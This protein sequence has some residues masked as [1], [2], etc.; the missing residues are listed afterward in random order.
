MTDK[1]IKN[2]L[3]CPLN[4]GL[5]HATR[6]IPV[7]E[8]LQKL[9]INVIIAAYGS[10][11][12]LLKKR[13][14]DTEIIYLSGFE[15]RYPKNGGMAMMLLSSFPGMI[16]SAINARKSFKRI[17]IEKNIDIV[18][19]DNRYEL[20]SKKVYSVFITHQLNIKTHGLQILAKP[21]INHIIKAFTNRFNEIWIPD[22]PLVNLSGSLSQNKNSKARYVGLLSRF[23]IHDTNINKEYDVV[24]IISGPE[25]QRT[26]FENIIMQQ[27]QDSNLHCAII[28][29]KPELDKSLQKEN[30]TV[31]P[32]LDDKRFASLISSAKLIISR[33]GYS[34][35][36][37]LANF[38]SKA[39]FVPTPGQTE[40]IYLANM[41]KK[42][43]IAYTMNQKDFDLKKSIDKSVYFSG[44]KITNTT[45]LLKDAIDS[46][47]NNG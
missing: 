13:F 43:Q 37:D 32:H 45:S 24:A 5:G 33:P 30:I 8:M 42:K 26:I 39:V 21:I 10:S 14:P 23:H 11:E 36:M 29:G 7:I 40:Q 25:P 22:D 47:L 27:M 6:M 46:V 4:W 9:N 18:I 44:L 1:K 34:T 41:M 17:L 38:G 19:S 20:Y 28:S 35:L 15:P 16:T 2:I 31:Y 12:I 3:I